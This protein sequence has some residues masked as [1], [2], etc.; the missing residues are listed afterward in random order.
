MAEPIDPKEVVIMDEL[1][2]SNMYV[3][4]K[5]GVSRMGKR[6]R[7]DLLFLILIGFLG[8]FLEGTS[9]ATTPKIAA[10][11]YHTLALKSDGTLWA[12]GRNAEG[13]LGDGTTTNRTSPVQIGTEN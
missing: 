3:L 13:Q 8:F 2:I 6:I 9:W 4:E 1:T 12:W 11:G 7:W 5:K 10:G